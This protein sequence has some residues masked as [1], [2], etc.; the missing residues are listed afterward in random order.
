MQNRFG[1]D[2]D[3]MCRGFTPVGDGAHP[4]PP[5]R[6]ALSVAWGGVGWRTARA[7]Q[8]PFPGQ[9]ASAPGDRNLC[10]VRSRIADLGFLGDARRDR[11]AVVRRRSVPLRAAGRET[12]PRAA[13]RR[14]GG[15]ALRARPVIS[16]Y[17]PVCGSRRPWQGG[18]G[19]F[20][21]GVGGAGRGRVEVRGGV[22]GAW[23]GCGALAGARDA[24]F[25]A[26][27]TGPT[28]RRRHPD[29]RRRNPA[30][31]AAAIRAVVVGLSPGCGVG[32]WGE[33]WGSGEESGQGAAGPGPG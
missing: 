31:I 17:R 24:E 8:G 20:P 33:V 32:R 22:H 9:G 13:A 11:N 14:G 25:P 3:E 5:R 6:P 23:K 2:F 27:W 21:C 26:R 4:A 7:R 16:N 15:R 10:G 29:Q 12:P 30:R 28:G 19:P 18:P 1:F